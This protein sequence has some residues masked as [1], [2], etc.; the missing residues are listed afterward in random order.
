[1]ASNDVAVVDFPCS[2][3]SVKLRPT[4]YG[5]LECLDLGDVRRRLVKTAQRFVVVDVVCDVVV[6]VFKVQER[7]FKV[8]FDRGDVLKSRRVVEVVNNFCLP[9]GGKSRRRCP[10]RV[11]C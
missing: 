5:I 6:E 3:E 11:V 2:N 4:A 10:R 8:S 7:A 9:V 1:M